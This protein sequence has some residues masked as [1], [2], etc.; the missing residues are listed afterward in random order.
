SIQAKLVQLLERKELLPAGG[1]RPV[2]SDVRLIA[3]TCKDLAAEMQAG[4]FRED[5]C[6]RLGGMRLRLP[7]LRERGRDMRLL[8]WHFL[9]RFASRK[10]LSPGAL[11][12]LQE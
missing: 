12:A 11:E 5:L 9:E 10:S 7:P 1:G 3:A 6:E 8:A 2:R 4:R